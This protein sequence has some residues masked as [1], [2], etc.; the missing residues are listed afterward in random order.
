MK[1][2]VRGPRKGS[3][4]AKPVHGEGSECAGRAGERD[5]FPS[6]IW[7]ARDIKEIHQ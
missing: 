2:E 6:I 7:G 4:I 3:L 5:R 1:G